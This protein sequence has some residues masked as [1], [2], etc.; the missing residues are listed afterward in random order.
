[1]NYVTKNLEFLR[2]FQNITVNDFNI[3]ENYRIEKI[4]NSNEEAVLRFINKKWQYV[5]NKT[6]T[7]LIQELNVK[8]LDEAIIVL[9]FGI[10][11]HLREIIKTYPLNKVLVLENDFELLKY[12]MTL[13]DLTDVISNSRLSIGLFK[14]SDD[15]TAII[16][17]YFGS[18]SHISIKATNYMQCDENIIKQFFTVI[19]SYNNSM[20]TI[21]QDNI[22]KSES[23]LNKTSDLKEYCNRGLNISLEE[24]RVILNEVIILSNNGSNFLNQLLEFM[25]GNTMIDIEYVVKKYNEIETNFDINSS[26]N[27]AIEL[28]TYKSMYDI[29]HSNK[30]RKTVSDDKRTLQIKDIERNIRI[31]SVR[32]KCAETLLLNL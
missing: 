5:S 21:V 27:K 9:G 8:Y 26:L 2:K 22:Q 18:Q 30:Y 25:D 3:S 13:Q 29:M 10:G 1:M 32:K 4:K 16:M 15:I 23:L 6:N 24:F 19:E 17:H 12:S 7:T 20:H 31:Y 28:P 11:N 14:N